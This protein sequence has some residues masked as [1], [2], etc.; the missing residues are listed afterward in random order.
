MDRFND[1]NWTGRT[2]RTIGDT[3][4]GAHATMQGNR[5]PSRLVFNVVSILGALAGLA[6]VAAAVIAAVAVIGV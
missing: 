2:P 5:P 6:V 1:S 4:L 3:R